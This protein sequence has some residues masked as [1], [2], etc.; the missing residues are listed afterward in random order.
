MW[1]AEQN[2]SYDLRVDLPAVREGRK[3]DRWKEM[4]AA[5]MWGIG[6]MVSTTT[7]TSHK[8]MGKLRDRTS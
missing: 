1:A 7:T 6:R 5:L 2:V 3:A 8:H 4:A